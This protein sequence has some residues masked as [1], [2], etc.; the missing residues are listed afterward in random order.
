[1]SSALFN[2]T[3]VDM[4]RDGYGVRF[5]AGGTSMHPTIRDGEL[6]TVESLS[7]CRFAIG[8][9]ILYRSERGVVAHRLMKIEKR[10]KES[11]YIL[12]GDAAYAP[13]EPVTEGRLLG[14]VIA[15]QRRGRTINLKI[16]RA[17]CRER[18]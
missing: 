16:G 9:I 13:D 3:C 18:V 12:R 6:I 1:M 8:D 14:R 17:S 15:V 5:R 11:V 10:E 7:G 4:L 2:E